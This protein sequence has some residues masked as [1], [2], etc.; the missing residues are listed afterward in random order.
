MYTRED[1]VSEL[2]DGFVPALCNMGF[3]GEMPH[4]RRVR[5]GHVDLLNIQFSAGG[6]RFAITLSYAD[7]AGN[8]LTQSWDMP[9]EKLKVAHTNRRRRLGAQDDRTDYWFNFGATMS[10]GTMVTPADLVDLAV[11]LLES[12]GEPWW[13]RRLESS[14]GG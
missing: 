3:E 5:G 1:M 7:A 14:K 11:E 8:N 10:T 2:E 13:E 12:Q 9:V 4:F 6:E